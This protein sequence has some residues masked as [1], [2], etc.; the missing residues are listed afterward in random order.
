MVQGHSKPQPFELRLL[1][2]RLVTESIPYSS[3]KQLEIYYEALLV[4]KILMRMFCKLIL[5]E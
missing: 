2:K 3:L 4:S 1:L 5:T